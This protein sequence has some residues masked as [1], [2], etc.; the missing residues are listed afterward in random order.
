[1]NTCILLR[2]AATFAVIVA[3]LLFQQGLHAQYVFN[4]WNAAGSAGDLYWSSPGNWGFGRVPIPTDDPLFDVYG[5]AGAQGTVNNIVDVSLTISSLSY[6]PLSSTNA[7]HTTQINPGVTLSVVPQI[8]GG[9]AIAVGEWVLPGNGVPTTNGFGNNDQ[10]Y[11]TIVGTNAALNVNGPKSTIRIEQAQTG[12]SHMATLDMSDLSTFTANISNILVGANIAYARPN[13]TLILAQTN[14]ITTAAM[15]ANIPGILLGCG[16]Y[17][18][19][20]GGIGVLTLGYANVFNADWLAVGGARANQSPNGQLGF[21]GITNGSFKLRGS[22]GGSTRAPLFSV[23]D[24]QAAD[25]YTVVRPGTSAG[26][27]GSS[28]SSVG[29]AEFRGNTVD[30]LVDSLILGRNLTTNETTAFNTGATGTGNGTLNFDGGVID[31]NSLYMGYKVGTNY[32]GAS[33]TLLANGGTLNV[34]NNVLMTFRSR[35]N[36]G[37]NGGNASATLTLASNAMANVKGDIVKGVPGQGTSTLNLNYGGLL[38]MEPAGD[39]VPGN[40]AVDNLNINSGSLINVSNLTASGTFNLAGAMV[41]NFNNLSVGTLNLNAGGALNNFANFTA[42]TVNLNTGGALDTFNNLSVSGTLNLNGG[43]ISSVPTIT[44][45]TLTGSGNLEGVL[46]VTNNTSLL[47]GGTA[48]AGTITNGGNLTLR[49]NASLAFAVADATATTPNGANSYVYVTGNFALQFSNV[50]SVAPLAPLAPGTCRLV[51]YSGSL[52]G[53]P[54]IFTNT[55]RY[56]LALDTGTPGQINLVTSSGGGPVALTWKGSSATGGTNWNLIAA[57]NWNNQ[58]EPF[59]QGD[60]VTFDANGVT[61]NINTVGLLYPQSITVSDPTRNYSFVGGGKISGG[62][63]INKSGSGTLLIN[64]TGGNDFTGPITVAAPGILKIGR[65][66]AFGSTNGTTTIASGATLDLNGTAAYNPGEFVTVSGTGVNGTGAITNSGGDVQNGLRYL[67]L[68][69][70]ASTGVNSPGRWDV[71]GPGGQ[72]SF[73][74]GLYLNGF[75][76]TKTGPGKHELADTVCTMAGNLVNN[77]GTLAFTRSMVDGPGT[78][79]VLSTNILQLEN[80]TTGYVAKPIIFTGNGTLTANGSAFTLYSPVTNNA[81]AALTVDASVNL[82]LTNVLTGPGG[83]TKVSAGSLILQAPDTCLGP[84]TISA[85]GIVLSNAGAMPNTPSIS[86]ASGTVLDV[87]GIGG[88]T[89]NGAQSLSGSG[90][91]IG[92]LATSTGTT[93]A[94]GAGAIAGT[95]TV[96][97]NLSLNN[98]TNLIELGADP[99]AIGGG[100]NDL[101]AA[102][103]NLGLT[104][105]NTI[106]ITPL[107][108]LDTVTPYTVMTYSNALSGGAPNL[109]VTSDNPRYVFGLVN[110]VTGPTNV[111][112]VNVSG[113]PVT[114][115]WR[116]GAAGNPNLWDFGTTSN[117]FNGTSLDVFYTGDTVQFDDTSATGSV[118]VNSTVQPGSM[119][120][121]NSALSYTLSGPGGVTAGGLTKLGSGSFTFANAGTNIFATGITLDE[122]TLAFNP[123]TN[124]ILTAALSD[125]G[126]GAGTLQ[127]LG[128]NILTLNPPGPAYNTNYTGAILVSA[129]TLKPSRRDA[130][131]TTN[132]LLTVASG[133]TLDVNGQ[134]LGRKYVTAS[135]AGAGGLGAIY[136]SAGGQNNALFNVTLAGDTTFGGTGR[137]D[138][139]GSSVTDAAF[140]SAGGNPYNLTKVGSNQVSLVDVAVDDMLGNIDVKEGILDLEANTMSISGGLGDASKTLTVYGNAQLKFYDLNNPLNKVISLLDGSAITNAHGANFIS[141]GITL[142]GTNIIAVGTSSLSLNGANS[143]TGN[144]LNGTGNLIKNGTGTLNLYGANNWSGDCFINGGTVAIDNSASF[145]TS[146]NIIVTTTTGGG[147]GSGTRIT[148]GITADGAW[149]VPPGVSVSLASSEPGDLRS[150]L[151]ANKGNSEW[152]GPI[153]CY[154]QAGAVTPGRVQISSDASN[155]VF[156]IRGNVSGVVTNLIFRGGN[157]GVG[158]IYGSINITNPGGLPPRLEKTEAS[159]WTLYN[160][161]NSWGDTTIHQGTLQLGID[162]PV[163]V[164]GTMEI[165]E[166]DALSQLDLNGFNQ[167]VRSLY[168][169]GRNAASGINTN[170]FVGNGSLTTDSTLTILGTNVTVF[171]GTIMDGAFQWLPESWARTNPISGSRVGLT[172]AAGNSGTLMLD[173][174]NLYTG[175]TLLNGGTLLV[176]RSLSNTVV[177]VNSGATLGGTGIILGPVTVNSGGT[178]AAGDSVGTLAISNSLTLAAGST[179]IVEV[180]PNTPANDQVVGVGTLTYDGTLVVTNV[181]TT[182]LAGGTV[183]KLFDAAS[184]SGAFA[185]IV[186]AEPGPGMFWDTSHLAVNG[187]L[188]VGALQFNTISILPDGNFQFTFAGR[189]GDNYRVWASD[190]LSVQ[191]IIGGWTLLTSG[192]FGSAPVTFSDLHATNFTHRF[193]D[194]S[195]P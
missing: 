67:S 38:N 172:L 115:S 54:V 87:S 157:Q 36:G 117:W 1:M 188:R 160:N 163:P 97:G 51:D 111:I 109:R 49:T 82:A 41:S 43:T 12:G 175:P 191:P 22:A 101:I 39:T 147:G 143:F 23:G 96:S 164:T 85:G 110:P 108:G 114:L 86:L 18:A 25:N 177:T 93:L 64:N 119:T 83:I 158:K 53:Q 153:I 78:V 58:T 57:T 186:P 88:L 24:M 113:I 130:L 181:T 104:G 63:G 19:T 100:V 168:S 156:T 159:L 169:S 74:G 146:K 107:A 122:G 176:D 30:I 56:N 126:A 98:T 20:D 17:D 162:N 150:R 139:R 84:T 123:T 8:L 95:L 148:V 120:I 136:N 73:S 94:P 77:G 9:N 99:T 59:F 48:L 28:R 62:A 135:G 2:R 121:N 144:A 26:L 184:Y 68:A 142:N 194:I 47:P 166:S 60:P 155:S 124:M 118:T 89:L 15:G 90:T 132:G 21:G 72:G 81:P 75:T 27:W 65:A 170:D 66:D 80:N 52:L 37:Y 128:T 44:A 102:G 116:G 6:D 151:Y 42:S 149:T 46:N 7:Y 195:V 40:V 92:N 16:G 70:D 180:N 29:T 187:T 14:T 79:T 133:G 171:A 174:P 91:L 112:Q 55:T 182:P 192:T 61:T 106:K 183:L 189:S 35:P 134:N 45:G 165:G 33:G 125:R 129:G 145:A 173:G 141:G 103:G 190:D 71:R 152:Q 105:V 131:G 137:W 140:L 193:Y 69:A 138:I 10:V 154:A 5:V 11:A 161:N 185:T 4:P 31:V 13:G 167:Q 3:A 50:L 179:T 32:G 34:A 76:Y 127:K 178:L